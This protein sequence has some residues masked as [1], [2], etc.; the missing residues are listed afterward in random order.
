MTFT[1]RD[2]LQNIPGGRR[3]RDRPGLA[4]AFDDLVTVDHAQIGI[5]VH[6]LPPHLARLGRTASGLQDETKNRFRAL[7]K[8]SKDFLQL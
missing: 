3:E 4:G 8:C 2:L 6:L 1:V 7:G 5:Q